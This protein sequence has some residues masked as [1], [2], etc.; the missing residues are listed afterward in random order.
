MFCP[1]C[2]AEYRFGFTKCSDCGV[3][4]V[5]RLTD[6]SSSARWQGLALAWRGSDPS[7]FSAALAVLKDAGIACAEISDHNHFV[8]GLAIPRPRYEILVHRA[9]LA[10]ALELVA[11]FTDRGL[12]ADVRENPN[13][14]T[15]PLET[16]SA[17]AESSG[18]A[19]LHRKL[20]HSIDGFEAEAANSLVWSGED[21]RMPQNIKASLIE[22][23]IACVIK[24][25]G[26]AHRVLVIPA[27]ETRAKE[28][29]REIVEQSPPQ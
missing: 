7:G 10:N 15:Q 8:W 23:G 16:E 2:K 14:H 28:I 25:E 11:P 17:Q 29:V 26:R 1:Q 22:N 24:K 19:R 13:E 20:K 27:D 4:L 18:V 6:D 9:D 3:D 21:E 12:L 5:E